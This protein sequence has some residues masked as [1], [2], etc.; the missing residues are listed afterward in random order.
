[1]GWDRTLPMASLWPP[2]RLRSSL[3]P[4]SRRGTGLTSRQQWARL[5]FSSWRPLRRITV[6]SLDSAGSHRASPA[7]RRWTTTRPPAAWPP[8]TLVSS[9]PG[10]WTSA[11]LRLL[12]LQGGFLKLLPQEDPLPVQGA[13]LGR[14]LAPHPGIV[15]LNLGALPPKSLGAEVPGTQHQ[16]VPLAP[17]Q[18]RT[19]CPMSYRPGT[20]LHLSPPTYAHTNGNAG[21]ASTELNRNASQNSRI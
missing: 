4:S 10:R 16:L 5:P 18:L 12:L 21:W 7:G 11:L 1:M 3:L 8:I 2:A 13:P 17:G 9:P 15:L 14:G 20:V 19:A 6:L